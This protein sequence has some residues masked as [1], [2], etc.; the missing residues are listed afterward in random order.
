MTSRERLATRLV[1]E[2]G[3]N[4]GPDLS[5]GDMAAS[6]IRDVTEAYLRIIRQPSAA[7][8]DRALLT[9]LRDS[10]AGAVLCSLAAVQRA[11]PT[12]FALMIA[13]LVS[14]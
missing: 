10:I 1:H 4:R 5:G 11:V 13:S 12:S 3:D 8:G 2:W 7:A 14:N 6:G 9:A